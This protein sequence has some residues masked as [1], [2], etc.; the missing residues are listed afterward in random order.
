MKKLF[1]IGHTLSI[2]DYTSLHLTGSYKLLKLGPDFA[3]IKSGDYIIEASG[4]DLTVDTLSEEVAVFSFREI[5]AI[6]LKLD[7][8]QGSFYGE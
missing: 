4:E 5:T 3:I 6:S 8:Q 2:D 7:E 1:K